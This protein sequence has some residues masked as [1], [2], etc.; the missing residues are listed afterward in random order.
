MLL[1]EFTLN[2]V[3]SETTG[4]SPFF[5]NY[6]FNPRL[7][8]EPLGLLHS[9]M[10]TAQKTGFHKAN[11]VVNRFEVILTQLKA[12]AQQS[13]DKYKHYANLRREDALK[14]KVS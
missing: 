7:G 3:I 13:I 12:L 5:A 6:S 9:D 4:V 8:T 2:N 14:Y 11:A 1:A 10:S